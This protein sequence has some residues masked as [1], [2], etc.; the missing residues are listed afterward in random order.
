MRRPSPRLL[1]AGLGAG[2]AALLLALP[3]ATAPEGLSDKRQEAQRILAEMEELDR[4]LGPVVE[5]YNGAT[6]ELDRI[7]GELQHTRA[8]LGSARTSFREAERRIAG[9]VVELYKGEEPDD[10]EVL[11]GAGSLDELLDRADAL[12]RVRE[13]DARIVRQIE[14]A[15]RSLRVSE[16]ELQADRREQREL[17][18]ERAER[19]RAIEAELA[20]RQV[21]YDQVKDEIERIQAAERERQARLER[22]AEQRLAQYRAAL[23]DGAESALASGAGRPEV[24]SLALQF[25]G[26]PYVWGGASPSGFDCSGLALYV[27]AK[28]GISLPHYAAYQYTYGRAVSRDELVP[29]DLVFFNG[30][31]HMGIYIGGGQFVH[32]PHTG[33]VVKISSLDEAWY[34]ASWV[35]ARRL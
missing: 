31:G 33:D 1:L 19:K 7:E 18:A 30:L 2:G 20:D 3:A 15:R 6:V 4:R 27:Y 29:G 25:L 24:V 23:N 32:A 21:L 28:I 16:K 17:V 9:R 12:D 11:L 34:A 8:A 26:V 13:Q 22:L 14:E 35:G 10:V 5:A